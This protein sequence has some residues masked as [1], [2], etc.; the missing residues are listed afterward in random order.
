[1]APLF[2]QP[3]LNVKAEKKRNFLFARD[4]TTVE[5]VFLLVAGEFLFLASTWIFERFRLESSS[6]RL[7]ANKEGSLYKPFYDAFRDAQPSLQLKVN[8]CS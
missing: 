1:M 4:E 3:F 5:A 2:I 8:V 7:I 6:Y